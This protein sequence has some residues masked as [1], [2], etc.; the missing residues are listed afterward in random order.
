MIVRRA[1]RTENAKTHAYCDKDAKVPLCGHTVPGH[2]V[3]VSHAETA[4]RCIPCLD[5]SE[6]AAAAVTKVKTKRVRR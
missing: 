6:G 2:L 5:A 4:R 3:R 1:Q